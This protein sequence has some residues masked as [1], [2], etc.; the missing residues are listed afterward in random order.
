MRT[1]NAI[2]NQR[3]VTPQAARPC[4]RLPTDGRLCK[5]RANARRIALPGSRAGLSFVEVVVAVA[6]LGLVAALAIPWVLQARAA[7][8][9]LSCRDHLRTLSLALQSYHTAQNQY[10]PAAFWS[11]THS[12]SIALHE[13]RRIDLVTH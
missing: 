4:G 10:P 12:A 3:F 9:L 11:T 8:R 13:A 7:S 6:I 1:R 2:R 5:P